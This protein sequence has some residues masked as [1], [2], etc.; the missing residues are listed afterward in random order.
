LNSANYNTFSAPDERNKRERKAI[1]KAT[2]KIF[3]NDASSS[4][5]SGLGLITHEKYESLKAANPPLGQKRRGRKRERDDYYFLKAVK[6]IEEIRIKL[7]TAKADGL[8]V[9]DR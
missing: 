1:A 2:P 6:K 8:T 7:K 3:V 5:Q 9:K 4:G